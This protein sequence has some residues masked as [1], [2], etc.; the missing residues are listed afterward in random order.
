MGV[1]L[2]HRSSSSDT[3]L[4]TDPCGKTAWKASG[5]SRRITSTNDADCAEGTGGADG[6]EGAF[7]TATPEAVRLMPSCAVSV[8]C[9]ILLVRLPPL[10]PQ[11]LKWED[12]PLRH[13][14]GLEAQ[15]VPVRDGHGPMPQELTYHGQWISQ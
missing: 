12:H 9:F 8:V 14:T 3:H 15:V 2:A 1:W 7:A 11:S 13:L 4:S 10:D 6:A 5:S